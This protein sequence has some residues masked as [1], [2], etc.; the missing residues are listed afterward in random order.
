MSNATLMIWV[1]YLATVGFGSFNVSICSLVAVVCAH[2]SLFIWSVTKSTFVIHIMKLCH[3][4][5]ILSSALVLSLNAL[6]NINYSN[7][8]GLPRLIQQ[9]GVVQLNNRG[10]FDFAKNVVH[11]CFCA[12]SAA[13]IILTSTAF[14]IVKLSNVK[15]PN[16][17]K[18]EK[19][20]KHKLHNKQVSNS[21]CKNLFK[22]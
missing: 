8:S 5:I 9:L 20:N 15:Q 3:L 17:L 16:T 7:S 10:N 2:L 4:L 1:V 21:F 11:F 22:Q 13:S 18:N 14:K 19:D 6:Y 12:F